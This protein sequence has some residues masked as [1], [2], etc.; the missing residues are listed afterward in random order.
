MLRHVY[1]CIC[2]TKR[3]IMKNQY[4]SLG[5]WDPRE[6]LFVYLFYVVFSRHYLVYV[7]RIPMQV[8]SI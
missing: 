3:N 6:N 1:I 4:G 2:N 7:F 8:I 5:F